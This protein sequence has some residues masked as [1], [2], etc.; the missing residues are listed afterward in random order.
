[1]RTLLILWLTPIVLL[2]TWYGLSVNDIN[3][4]TQVF[5]REMH[6]LVFKIY[7]NILG[8]DPE[9]IPMMVAKAIAFDSLFILAI[10]AYRLRK[11]WW[12]KFSSLF[13]GL[14]RSNHE[15]PA[16]DQGNPVE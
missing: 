10:I 4:G 7:G 14:F 8:I 11:K 9:I 12:P 5:S 1:M 15:L 2:G 6:D 13:S 16:A 3:L